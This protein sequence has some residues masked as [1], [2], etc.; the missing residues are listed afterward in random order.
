MGSSGGYV[1]VC[2]GMSIATQGYWDI[3][4]WTLDTPE[5]RQE[6]DF[7]YF[8]GMLPSEVENLHGA[9][10]VDLEFNAEVPEGHPMRAFPCA[11]QAARYNDGNSVP[12][13]IP[14]VEYILKY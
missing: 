12:S 8:T 1:G 5:E 11:N 13:N 2:A 4:G 10:R 7:P 9:R 6:H 14:G 3:E